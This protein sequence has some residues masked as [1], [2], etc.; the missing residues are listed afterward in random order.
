MWMNPLML[1]GLVVLAIPVAIHLAMRTRPR[2]MMFPALRFVEQS[3]RASSGMLKLKQWLLLALRMAALG[4]FVLLLARPLSRRNVVAAPDDLER[5]PAAAVLCLDNSPSMGYRLGGF[6]R[7]EEAK[8]KAA[9]I[10]GRLPPRSRYAVVDLTSA[11]PGQSLEGESGRALQAI[12]RVEL[13]SLSG[14]AAGML[15]TAENLLAPATEA[16]REI[17]LFTDMTEGAWRDLPPGTFSQYPGVPVYVID[18]GVEENLNLALG[19][20]RLPSRSVGRNATVDIR[21]VVSGGARPAWRTVALEIAGETRYL[22]RVELKHPWAESPVRFDEPMASEGAVQ[23]RV[24]F[25]EED[26]L[27]A[28]NVRYFTLQVGDPPA[29]AVVR[30]EERPADLNDDAHIVAEALAPDGLRQKGQAPVAP[31]LMAS[32]ALGRDPLTKFSAVFLVDAAGISDKGWAALERFVADGGGLVVQ[33]GA[34][35]A[36]EVAAGRSSYR[37]VMARRLLGVEV[38]PLRAPEG[39]VWLKARSF[40]DPALAAFEGDD[41]AEFELAIIHRCLVLR[42]AADARVVMTLGAGEAGLVAAGGPSGRVFTLATGPQKAWSVLAAHPQEFV[43]LMHSLLGSAQRGIWG[44]DGFVIGEPVVF[45][46]PADCAGRSVTLSGPGLANPETHQV[47]P[48]TMRATFSPLYQPGNYSLRVAMPGGP[49]L[50]G[51]SLNV[52]PLESRLERRSPADLADI[53][54]PGMVHVAAD[55]DGLDKAE[56]L[57]RRGREL[58]AWILPILM[59]VMVL[60]LLLAN[61]FYRRPAVAAQAE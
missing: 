31:V 29:V 1:T 40:D 18:V 48:T 2:Q 7:L 17:Y 21:S 37:S 34:D 51:F 56:T 59:A 35:V 43:V 45:G 13:S 11:G 58:T 61:R 53:F 4:L 30:S 50:F 49:R 41:N 44:P 25:I 46:F 14:S 47:N 57:V 10:V 8:R 52:D 5:V 42:P 60:E 9:A 3:H 33:F 24:L 32:S 54:A 27:A 6:T 12:E 26:E 55:L 38:G 20:P 36:A 39:G 19:C 23:G 22:V 16:R 15:R 28:D